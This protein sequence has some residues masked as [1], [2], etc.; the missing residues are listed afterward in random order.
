MCGQLEASRAIDKFTLRNIDPHP[1][2]F[3]RPSAVRSESLQTVLA[4]T[5]TPSK[6]SEYV[7]YLKSCE[8]VWLRWHLE[9]LTRRPKEAFV[10]AEF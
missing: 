2:L 1:V 7:A 5:R 9:T 3:A 4:R 8:I 10:A 6:A